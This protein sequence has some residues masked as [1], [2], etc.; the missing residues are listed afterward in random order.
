M[1]FPGSVV[2]FRGGRPGHPRNLGRNRDVDLHFPIL[3]CRMVRGVFSGTCPSG[4][5]PVKAP[6]TDKCRF[7]PAIPG[8][9]ASAETGT[10]TPEILHLPWLCCDSDKTSHDPDKRP[11]TI[12]MT[13]FE[14]G[15]RKSWP[16]SRFW[17]AAWLS[18]LG[19]RPSRHLRQQAGA[20]DPN[21]ELA[22]LR[23]PASRMAA[24][25]GSLSR[26]CWESAKKQA[27]RYTTQVNVTPR[28]R[29]VPAADRG[30]HCPCTRHQNL[31]RIAGTTASGDTGRERRSHGHTH[32]QGQ[33]S[34]GKHF[35][36]MQVLRKTGFT[37][38]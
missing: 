22:G 18:G 6:P 29:T 12:T 24:I 7:T 38:Q 31:R 33:G 10:W 13:H 23:P 25:P 27:Q 14:V 1:P 26:G 20:D 35:C 30:R 16:L 2:G 37:A 5:P 17:F 3:P 34:K 8:S 21:Y 28:P 15:L 19:P 11:N 4:D 32:T 36:R 9:L